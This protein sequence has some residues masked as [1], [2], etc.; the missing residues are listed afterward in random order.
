MARH[1]GV[2]PSMVW[3]ANGLK[4]HLAR[5]FK[6]GND[7]QFAEKVTDVVGLYLIWAQWQSRRETKALQEMEQQASK[8]EMAGVK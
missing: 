4:P 5:S 2:S 3:R 7:P 8:T 1:L 6:V